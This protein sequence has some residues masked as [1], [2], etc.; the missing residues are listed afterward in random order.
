MCVTFI[1]TCIFEYSNFASGFERLV[2]G[3]DGVMQSRQDGQDIFVFNAV[4]IP[5][6]L[7]LSF[8]LLRDPLVDLFNKGMMKTAN[9]F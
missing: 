2:V 1:S 3:F 7:M 5:F 8:L 4:V 9:L 6:A